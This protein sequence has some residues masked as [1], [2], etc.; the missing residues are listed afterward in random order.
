M[1]HR[2]LLVI[3]GSVAA[4]KALELIRLL[5]RETM[6]VTAILTEGG[7]EFITPLAVSSLTGTATYSTLFSLKDEVEMG[8]IRLSREHDLVVVAPASADFIAKM[9]AGRADDLA[10]ATLL[11]SSIPVMIAP[12][13]NHRMWE[14]P[15]T[16]RNIAQLQA[17]GI[18]VIAPT[19]GELACGEEGAGR[20][21][22]PEAILA[23]ISAELSSTPDLAPTPD[24]DFAIPADTPLRGRRA[25]VTSGPT[26]EAIDPVRYISNY[27]SGKQGHAI[28]RALAEAGAEVTLISGPVNEPTPPGVRLIRVTTAED[29][30][31]AAMKT[32][33]VDVAVC[34][35][36]VADWTVSHPADQKIKKGDKKAVPQLAFSPTKDILAAI[37]HHPSYRPPLVV[38]FAAETES[39]LSNAT[40]KRKE[41][42][43]DWLLA[44][45]VSAGAVFGAET[46]Q[47]TLVSDAVAEAWKPMSKTEAAT[48][49]TRRIIQKFPPRKQQK[50]PSSTPIATITPAARVA[51]DNTKTIEI[52]S[53]LATLVRP[54]A[55]IRFLASQGFNRNRIAKKLSIPLDQVKAT[56]KTSSKKK[57]TATPAARPPKVKIEPVQNSASGTR[58]PSQTAHIRHL[59]DIGMTIT[60]ITQLLGVRYPTVR[61][62]LISQERNKNKIT[63][64]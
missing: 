48:E 29:M 6:E 18:E 13:M 8:H 19:A 24:T 45:D 41:K 14:H 5:R 44:N 51:P 62:A 46:T 7:A 3:T 10:S 56:L 1:S 12:A 59:A 58:F 36:A 49:I 9:A 52:D 35:A 2:I 53:K 32:L 57:K 37:S 17:D 55:K 31:I 63:R 23:R 16:R 28:A 11:A 64:A 27:S 30:Y 33:P 43:C 25:L 39:V 42:G 22:A 34:A 50:L 26:Q 54:S 47:L 61:N 15:A 60:E 20:M 4:Y 21:A 38:G 40:N